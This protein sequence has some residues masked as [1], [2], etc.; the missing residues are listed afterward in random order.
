MFIKALKIY[1]LLLVFSV[2]AHAEKI[3]VAFGNTLAPW[4]MA[5]SHTGILIDIVKQALEP[6]GYQ[7]EPVYYPYARRIQSYQQGQVHAV[8]DIN[9]ANIKYLN[10]RGHFSGEIYKYEN[11]FYALSRNRF[12][13]SS[14]KDM[15]GSSLVSW[16]GAMYLLGEEYE[17]MAVA[18]PFYMETHNQTSQVKMLFNERV[19]VIQLDKNIFEYY[20]MQIAKDGYI[21]V[22]QGVD[23]FAFL[24]PNP[25][26]FMF[27]SQKV[28]DDFNR[29]VNKMVKN[30]QME[31][32]Y[33]K[34][35]GSYN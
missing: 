3:S 22:N 34:Y 31:K 10:L 32:I 16:Q 28:R 33:Q 8:C 11:Y 26:G 19:D 9:L 18:N 14:M 5:D 20:R 2:T 17:K 24:E 7:I 30:G 27:H 21:N 4:V 23:K 25:G 15:V 13:F 29:Q 6:L 12:Q 1:L 35:G